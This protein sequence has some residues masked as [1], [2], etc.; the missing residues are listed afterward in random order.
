MEAS[1]SPYH[2]PYIHHCQFIGITGRADKVI[3]MYDFLLK[4]TEAQA[5]DADWDEM[6]PGTD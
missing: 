2:E 4:E 6:L 5:S 3:A 1:E